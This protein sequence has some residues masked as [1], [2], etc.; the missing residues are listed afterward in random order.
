MVDDAQQALEAVQNR[1]LEE[2]KAEAAAKQAEAEAKSALDEL[3]AQEKAFNDKVEELTRKSQEGGTVSKGKA[4]NEL[5]QLKAEDPL[6]LRRAKINQAAT[7]R[8]VERARKEAEE[9]AANT[10]KAQAEAEGKFLAANKYLEEIQAKGGDACGD[11]WWL[12]REMTEKKKY[13]PR[14]RQ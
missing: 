6:P 13:L 10:A 2:R 4:S 7:V 9:T 8:K 1:L 3:H 11:I 12:Q 14:S 5:E